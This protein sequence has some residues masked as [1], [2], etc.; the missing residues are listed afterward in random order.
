MTF[1]YNLNTDIGK[2][3]FELQDVNENDYEF[4]DAELQYCI[5][6]GKGDILWASVYACEARCMKEC[7][8]NG[9]EIEVGDTRVKGGVTS[10][11]SW[12]TIAKE[13]RGVLED[14]LS[15][16][17]DVIPYA[18]TS[19]IFANDRKMN[20]KETEEG[21]L[22]ERDFYDCYNESGVRGGIVANGDE[23]ND[24]YNNNL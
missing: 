4:E 24:N 17:G 21:I 10:G 7:S 15:P 16:E 3:R 22:I 5:S 18:F 9:L 6:K 2:L 14:A 11:L 20:N 19:G 8:L 13:R 23:F 1:T 12:C